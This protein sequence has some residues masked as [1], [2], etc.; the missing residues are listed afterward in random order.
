MNSAKLK[1][2]PLP[3]KPCE[4]EPMMVSG[5]ALNGRDSAFHLA[6]ARNTSLGGV[7][8]N[9]ARVGTAFAE[10]KTP[11]GTAL[12]SPSP[13]ALAA[14]SSVENGATLY[15][16]GTTGKSEAAGA[17]FWALENPVSPGYAAR[18]GIPA[19]NVAKFN[20]I[21]TA[22]LRPGTPFVTRPAPGIGTNPGG[23]IEVV[24]PPNGVTMRFFG[25]Q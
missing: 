4:P 24:V 13:E 6:G 2:A 12:Q 16:L 17:Q 1:L 25:T 10:I 19:E 3:T 15:R 8:A 22:T 9:S 23:G 5:G 20:F 7:G 11:W 14:R 18:Y 21:E